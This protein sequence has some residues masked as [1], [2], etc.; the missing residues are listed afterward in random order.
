MDPNALFFPLY[1]SLADVIDH[2]RCYVCAAN[3]AKCPFFRRYLFLFFFLFFFSG[4]RSVARFPVN[5]IPY[6]RVLLF[7]ALWSAEAQSRRLMRF[8]A[9]A[10]I[11]V[12]NSLG[13]LPAHRGELTDRSPIR[14]AKRPCSECLE[15]SPQKSALSIETK[16]QALRL[17]YFRVIQVATQRINFPDPGS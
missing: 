13:V 11:Q 3:V 16:P 8:A 9:F 15:S 6:H 14:I 10:R 7:I 5:K 17:H 12:I 4:G 2:G 1:K